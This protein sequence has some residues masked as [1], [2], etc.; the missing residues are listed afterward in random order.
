MTQREPVPVEVEEEIDGGDKIEPPPAAIPFSTLSRALI[1]S[2]G[3]RWSLD[4]WPPPPTDRT[5]GLLALLCQ[6]RLFV[7]PR[8]SGH[9]GCFVE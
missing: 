3:Y 7:G 4:R 2:I 1:A 9:E 8:P 5:G 6:D